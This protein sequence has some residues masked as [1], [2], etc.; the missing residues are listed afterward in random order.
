MLVQTHRSGI[1]AEFP[2]TSP[3]TYV[4]KAFPTQLPAPVETRQ[5][6]DDLTTTSVAHSEDD[7]THSICSVALKLQ[8]VNKCEAL[9]E[10]KQV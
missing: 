10:E 6:V 1:G 2:E 8:D 9:P 7:V 4:D 5:F 3:G